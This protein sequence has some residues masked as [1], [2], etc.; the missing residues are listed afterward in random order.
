[1]KEHGSKYI[2]YFI[3]T[4]TLSFTLWK[5]TVKNTY[6]KA[7]DQR[8]FHDL[9]MSGSEVKCN[10]LRPDRQIIPMPIV[11]K[12]M[13]YKFWHFQVNP[14]PLMTVFQL[15]CSLH[16]SLQLLPHI[17]VS[18]IHQPHCH[19]LWCWITHSSLTFTQQCYIH[20]FII[21]YYMLH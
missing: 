7:L 16:C 13:Q 4:S 11:C 14:L 10:Q 6:L 2:K 1:M 15:T 20:L 5:L 21:M 12:R 3:K 18:F 9:W 17:S 8:C 19:G